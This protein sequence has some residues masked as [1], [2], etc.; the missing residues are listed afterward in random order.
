MALWL[1]EVTGTLAVPTAL[2]GPAWHAHTMTVGYLG[3][4]LAGYALTAMP[5]WTGR[6]PLQGLSLAA[7]V[8]TWVVGRAVNLVGAGLP[9]GIVLAADLAFPII[10]LSAVTREL[11]HGRGWRGLPIVLGFAGLAA[12]VVVAHTLPGDTLPGYRLA[13]AVFAGLI[14]VVGGRLIPSFTGTV[15]RK[16]RRTPPAPRGY[17]D[18]TAE[19]LSVAGG[20]AWCVLP[21]HPVTAG[22]AGLAC[23]ANAVRLLRWREWATVD[24]PALLGLHLGYAWLTL[25]LG[26][27]AAGPVL[28]GN[29]AVHA[30]AAGAMGMLPLAI[31]ARLGL[32]HA[33]GRLRPGWLFGLALG[34]VGLA[35]A[36]RTISPWLPN[37]L[38]V[39]GVLWIVGFVVAAGYLARFFV[40]RRAPAAP[41]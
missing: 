4:A 19:G 41:A 10:M 15:L 24:D 2:P 8:V 36:A 5:N 17:I 27:I 18:R 37:F 33:C 32:A 7:L 6:L 9:A 23:G 30:L 40:R 25:G 1:G 21:L 12:A 39:A 28:P 3:A 26:L 11:R 13:I 35:A 14:A 16:R 20:L 31:M 29:A 38:P 34:L 22:L